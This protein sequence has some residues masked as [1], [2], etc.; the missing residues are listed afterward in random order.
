MHV[1]VT[2]IPLRAHTCT[3]TTEQFRNCGQN[4]PSTKQNKGCLQLRLRIPTFSF[5]RSTACAIRMFT[6]R[7]ELA[8]TCNS[9]WN[10]GAPSSG[11]P[12][13]LISQQPPQKGLTVQLRTSRT[14]LIP[15]RTA[16]CWDNRI[17][18]ESLTDLV[19]LKQLSP[20]PT[21]QNGQNPERW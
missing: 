10:V 6:H 12:P 4:E 18:T 17:P 8:T 15:L 19:I 14:Y 5:A 11:L 2:S 20:L 16:F 3:H 7:A 13:S 21:Y 1:E 9:G